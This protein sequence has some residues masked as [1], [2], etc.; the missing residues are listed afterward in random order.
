MA[1]QLLHRTQIRTALKQVRRGRVSQAVRTD[2]GRTLHR[3]GGPVYDAAYLSRV[4]ASASS[5]E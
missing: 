5:T 4:D 2:V 1:E 3:L